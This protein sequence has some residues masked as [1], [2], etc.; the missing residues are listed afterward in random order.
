MFQDIPGSIHDQVETAE[1]IVQIS[2]LSC[3]FVL[4]RQLATREGCKEGDD[5]KIEDKSVSAILECFSC[6]S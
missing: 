2:I 4:R 1:I 6:R 3:V 5:A